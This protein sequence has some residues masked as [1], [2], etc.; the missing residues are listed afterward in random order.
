M[1]AHLFFQSVPV[2]PVPPGVPPPPIV[3][4]GSVALAVTDA[5]ARDGWQEEDAAAWSLRPRQVGEGHGMR[6]WGPRT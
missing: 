2:K 5:A 3:A 6:P 1:S 4:G